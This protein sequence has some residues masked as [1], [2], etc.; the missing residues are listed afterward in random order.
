MMSEKLMAK[1]RIKDEIKFIL[2]YPFTNI[3]INIEL[4]NDDN[5]LFEWK[6]YLIAP[7]DTN[8]RD[9]IFYFKIKFPQDYPK[10]GPEII[11]LTPIYHSNVNHLEQP[12]CSLGHMSISILNWWQSEYRIREILVKFYLAT[13]YLENPEGSYGLEIKDGY[14]HN[15]DLHQ[16]K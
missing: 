8:Y 7:D 2:D 5:N 14:L 1:E 9:G 16:K 4:P 13:F 6:G 11:F 3:G 12:G 10:R 15:Y